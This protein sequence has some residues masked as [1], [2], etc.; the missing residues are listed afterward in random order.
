MSLLQVGL[1]SS[2][3]QETFGELVEK[4]GSYLLHQGGVSI[5]DITKGTEL[6]RKQV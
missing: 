5:S 2:M 4:V 3:L 1:A 6:T